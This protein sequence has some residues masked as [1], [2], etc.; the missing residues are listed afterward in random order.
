MPIHLVVE[1]GQLQE[2]HAVGV[3]QHRQLLAV[4]T[5]WRR[6]LRAQREAGDLL[7]DLEQTQEALGGE[8]VA[9]VLFKGRGVQ[10]AQAVAGRIRA[11]R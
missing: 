1:P 3:E 8:V 5:P 9:A 10:V 7:V 4:G 11:R 2:L 6:E